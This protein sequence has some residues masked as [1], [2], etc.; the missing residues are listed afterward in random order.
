MPGSLD[1]VALAFHARRRWPHL[2]IVL[3]SGRAM[4]TELNLPERRRLMQ[5]PYATDDA[6]T[7][8]RDVMAT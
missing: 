8:V 3:V 1:G 2:G 7:S 6:V 4:P 5:K